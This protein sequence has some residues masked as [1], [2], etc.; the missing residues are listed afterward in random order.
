MTEVVLLHGLVLCSFVAAPHATSR[1]F[2]RRSKR[3]EMAYVLALLGLV[4]SAALDVRPLAGLWPLFCA[5]GFVLHLSNEGRRVLSVRGVARCIPFV[6]S[7]VSATWFVAARNDLKLLGYPPNW[8]FYAALHGSVLG[9]LVIGCTAH[10][11]SREKG[12]GLYLWSCYLSLP[13]FLFVAFGIDG[14][15][16]LKRIGAV[17][18]S[19][20]VPLVIGRFAL[21]L[22]GGPRTPLLLALIS[23]LGVVASMT[24]ALFNE[25]WVGFPRILLGMPTMVLLHGCLNALIVGPAFSLAIA[26]AQEG[27]PGGARA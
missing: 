6:F 13:L 9:W 4:V 3:Y 26:S 10:L 19:L 1:L 15:A 12:P 22:R 20:L 18:L 16:H 11:A 17:G 21:E 2:L 8:S 24:L 5:F 14:V 27:G 7:L 25:F 23:V